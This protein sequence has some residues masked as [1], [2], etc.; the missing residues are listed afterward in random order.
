MT[1]SF[2]GSWQVVRSARVS[3]AETEEK[4]QVVVEQMS[5]GLDRVEAPTFQQ[6]I[7]LKIT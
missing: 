4:S 3:P 5:A 2:H 7:R 1:N 6:P